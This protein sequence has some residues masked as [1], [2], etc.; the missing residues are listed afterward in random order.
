[1][2]DKWPF[3]ERNALP[4]QNPRPQHSPASSKVLLGLSQDPALFLLFCLSLVLARAQ[5][6]LSGAPARAQ[7]AFSGAPARAQL[8][9]S[10]YSGLLHSSEAD[11]TMWLLVHSGLADLH[12]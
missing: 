1:M 10:V 7:L 11:I 9:F 2:E 8:A 5:L 3:N 12:A 6:A 4:S